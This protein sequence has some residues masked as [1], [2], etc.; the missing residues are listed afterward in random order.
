M[1]LFTRPGVRWTVVTALLLIGLIV[2][3]CVLIRQW[4]PAL[5]VLQI[6]ATLWA[7]VAAIALVGV[8]G[9][10]ASHTHQL[11]KHTAEREQAVRRQAAHRV[12]VLC[13]RLV[14]VLGSDNLPY[15]NVEADRLRTA[16]WC[17]GQDLHDLESLAA[18][19]GTDEATNCAVASVN[20]LRWIGQWVDAAKRAE[21]GDAYNRNLSLIHWPTWVAK[22]GSTKEHL[23]RLSE[24][25]RRQVAV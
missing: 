16:V 19:L 4:A 13:Q 14:A 12:V 25:A 15:N 23:G 3:T 20:N 6:V 2:T 1:T 5:T 8:T 22:I 18:S 10:Y 7:A 17:D 24:A 21:D 11:V 9:W